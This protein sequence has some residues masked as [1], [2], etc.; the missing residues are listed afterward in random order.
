MPDTA[1]SLVILNM[2]SLLTGA[3]SVSGSGTSVDPERDRCRPPRLGSGKLV[4]DDPC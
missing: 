1:V 4:L 3:D 2:V